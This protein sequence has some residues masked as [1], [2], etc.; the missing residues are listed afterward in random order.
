M[1]VSGE[2]HDLAALSLE[3]ESLVPIGKKVE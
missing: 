1:E 2:L 3:K